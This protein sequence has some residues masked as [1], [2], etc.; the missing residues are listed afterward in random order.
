MGSYFHGIVLIIYTMY[1]NLVIFMDKKTPQ[2]PQK[3]NLTKIKI[4]KV[5]YTGGH[6]SNL[7]M[8]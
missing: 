8:A 6:I 7:V 3:L 1:I 5:Y 4:H 2:N